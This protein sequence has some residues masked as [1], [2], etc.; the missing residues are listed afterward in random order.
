MDEKKGLSPLS[1]LV[2]IIGIICATFVGY[3]IAQNN[4]YTTFG[5]GASMNALL[6]DNWKGEP[7]FKEGWAEELYNDMY[8]NNP[9]SYTRK[10]VLK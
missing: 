4:R 5:P 2:I 9:K 8:T 6:W 10:K 3:R 7:V 1:A